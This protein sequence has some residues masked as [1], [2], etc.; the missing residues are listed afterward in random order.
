MPYTLI[1]Y[2]AVVKGLLSDAAA[3]AKSLQSCPTL[4]DPI[5]RPPCKRRQTHNSKLVHVTWFCHLPHLILWMVS[6]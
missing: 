6:F 3:A 4:C 2:S 1:L 5:D